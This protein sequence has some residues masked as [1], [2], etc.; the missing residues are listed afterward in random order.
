MIEKFYYSVNNNI[1]CYFE[2]TIII[3]KY[4]IIILILII[5]VMIPYRVSSVSSTE[6]NAFSQENVKLASGVLRVPRSTE[7]S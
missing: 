6:A 5:I 3:I 7:E 4:Y 2:T 1:Y